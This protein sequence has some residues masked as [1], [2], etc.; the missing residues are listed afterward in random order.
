MTDEADSD[1]VHDKYED[2]PHSASERR[3]STPKST[4]LSL[5]RQSY[6]PRDNGRLDRYTPEP[7]MYDLSSPSTA[8]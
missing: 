7:E 4:N 1:W 2:D 6:T 5:A 8:H 3:A